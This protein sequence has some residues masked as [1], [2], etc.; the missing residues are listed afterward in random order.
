MK[1]KFYSQDGK[2]YNDVEKVFQ[3]MMDLNLTFDY[4][5]GYL[6]VSQGE[7]SAVMIN[8]SDSDTVPAILPPEEEYRLQVKTNFI[9]GGE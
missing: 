7:K 3:L 9:S 2:F 4:V 1:I 8:I 5:N 6:E